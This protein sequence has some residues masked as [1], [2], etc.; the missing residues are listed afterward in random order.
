MGCDI[1]WYSETKK[2]DKWVCDQASTFE[3]LEE[4]GNYPE[5]ENFLHRN[6]DYGFFGLLQ[7]GVRSSWD[8]SFPEG[9]YPEDTSTEVAQI[10]KH[11][12]VDAHSAGSRSREALKAKQEELKALRMLALISPSN[13]DRVLQHH[14]ECLDEVIKN[15]DAEVPDT[16]QRIVFWFDN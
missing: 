16:D 15:L 12:G 13:T 1:H 9:N 2:N 3:L 7:P 4:D 8:W 5:M 11:W 6:W 14:A 10:Y